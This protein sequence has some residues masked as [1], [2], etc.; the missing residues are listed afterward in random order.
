[1]SAIGDMVDMR[2]TSCCWEQHPVRNRNPNPCC[3]NRGLATKPKENSGRTLG[4]IP[5]RSTVPPDG[6]I[7]L[8]YSHIIDMLVVGDL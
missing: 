7:D 3:W 1:M 5:A 4:G 2:A 6:E 8:L